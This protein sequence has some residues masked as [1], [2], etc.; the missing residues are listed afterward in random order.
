MKKTII[1]CFG[2]FS[3]LMLHAQTVNENTWDGQIWFKVKNSFIFRG[4]QEYHTSDLVTDTFFS[5]LITK[6][7]ITDI[8]KPFPRLQSIE[9][10]LT[11]QINFSAIDSVESLIGELA[12]ADFIEY[13]ERI[14]IERI[15]TTPNDVL[16]T[17]PPGQ[18]ALNQ[19]NAV[20]AWT[21]HPNLAGYSTNNVIIAVV[22]DAVRTTHEDIAANLL[23]N[24]G[25]LGGDED[26]NGYV[27]DFFYGWDAA[28]NVPN[29]NPPSSAFNHGTHVAG[30]AAGVTDNG[31]G[32]SSLSW[33]VRLMPIKASSHLDPTIISNAWGGVQYAIVNGADV[34]NMSWGS[35]EF[36]NTIQL[37]IDDG[38]LQGIIFVAGAGNDGNNL[39]V[40]P[41]FPAMCNGVIAVGSTGNTSHNDEKSS[42]SNYGVGIDVM[43]PGSDIWSSS[44][45]SGIANNDYESQSGT[46]M[47]SP[48]VASLVGL[49]KSYNPNLTTSEIINCITSTCD[50]ISTVGLNTS[51][52]AGQLGAGR[53]NA[54]AA[55]Q[56]LT[57]LNSPSVENIND[58]Q[59]LFYLYPNPSNNHVN[60]SFSQQ[61]N[62]PE[63]YTIIDF[64]GKT[65]CNEK[66]NS[67]QT[68]I[69]IS[70]F[71][72]G[73]Y[74]LTINYNG[75]IYT[76][77]I[78]KQ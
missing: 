73:I 64:L 10:Q 17:N 53:I 50:D 43:A 72:N 11:Y 37:I 61:T 4:V 55:M 44:N 18:W 69:D 32:I 27:G 36:S 7:S 48:L 77:K 26:G 49:M 9:L 31:F 40:N 71:P 15:G 42:F 54:Q 67:K 76:G 74:L 70:S 56:C 28:H 58:E 75:R 25:E 20:G 30:I 39:A 2:L 41:F 24:P 68:G 34:I 51:Y 1:V 59:R 47:A 57:A 13:A 21:I 38:T 5:A 46:S 62:L 3:Y 14:P 12:E 29:P 6:Y 19:I 78:I 35:Y 16:Y 52:T 60:L 23:A 8:Y 66:I 65:I 63:S 33:N 22:D 45:S